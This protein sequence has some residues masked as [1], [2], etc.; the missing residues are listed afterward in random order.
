MLKY[1]HWLWLSKMSAGYLYLLKMLAK[2]LW[3]YNNNDIVLCV[4]SVSD[5]HLHV[6]GLCGRPPVQ[7]NG[8]K[9]QR[10]TVY[11]I[12][13]RRRWWWRW[14]GLV[15][16]LTGIGVTTSVICR[17][18]ATA[19]VEMA[20]PI[21]NVVVTLA[22]HLH[23]LFVTDT[24]SYIYLHCAS[25]QAAL[26]SLECSGGSS[27]DVEVTSFLTSTALPPGVYRLRER[28]TRKKMKKK[29]AILSVDW[30]LEDSFVYPNV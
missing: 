14:W 9:V 26:Q 5:P 23:G 20:T 12:H 21:A 28:K 4:C 24:P 30:V 16:R 7:S 11:G 2:D 17:Y 27:S 29:I 25:Q 8:S 19:A 1:H 6:H 10:R 22:P 13:H 3:L 18:C 15:I